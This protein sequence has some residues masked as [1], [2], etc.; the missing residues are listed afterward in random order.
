MEMKISF[1]IYLPS[2]YFPENLLPSSDLALADAQKVVRSFFHPKKRSE[3]RFKPRNPVRLPTPILGAA[4]KI[5]KIFLGVL[6][7]VV[8]VVV[9]DVAA[10]VAV[11][12]DVA[13]AQKVLFIRG[14]ESQTAD[15]SF[16]HPQTGNISK[17]RTA[18]R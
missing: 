2:L 12:A 10:S 18:Q 15:Q 4:R 1:K 6:P 17:F 14:V 11:A 16:V 13:V 3:R 5:P 9:A 8:A 7:L